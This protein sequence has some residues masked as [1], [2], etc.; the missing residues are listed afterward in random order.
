MVAFA[1]S[2]FGNAEYVSADSFSAQIDA[3]Q[4]Q[5]NALNAEKKVISEKANTLANKVAE[6]QNEQDLLQAEINLNV[7]KKD[8]L[9]VKIEENTIKLD[10]Q[11]KSLAQMLVDLHFEGE[12]D[13]LKI[14]AGSKSISDY[15]NI[16]GSYLNTLNSGKVTLQ[17][18]VGELNYCINQLNNFVASNNLTN[19]NMNIQPCKTLNPRMRID[20][21]AAILNAYTVLKNN[22]TE[23]RALIND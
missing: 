3:L 6:L 19:K 15:A 16:C 11:Q 20:G 2:I 7:A 8:D 13:A 10:N 21:M 5:I 1:L 18:Y 9:T 17:N 4:K 23:Y 14:L 12:A 22:E